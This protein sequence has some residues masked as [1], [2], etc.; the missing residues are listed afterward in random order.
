MKLAGPA[1]ALLVRGR[2]A[3]PQLLLLDG[4]RGGQGRRGA[5]CEG[6]HEPLVLG[7]ERC[8]RVKAV[9]RDEDADAAAMEG[10]WHEHRHAGAVRQIPEAESHPARHLAQRSAWPVRSTSPSAVP[11][12]GKR[13]PTASS[14]VSPAAAATTSSCIL[15]KQDQELAGV[16]ERAAALDHELED[17]VQV[18]F[19]AHRTRDR[20]GCLQPADGALEL[21]AA[22]VDVLVEVGVLDGDRHPARQD[23]EC[24]LVGLVE[25]AALLL[26]QID[27]APGLAAH[28]YRCAEEGR[29]RRM[30]R[31][32]SRSCAGAG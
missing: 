26:G 1:A 31:A 4:L 30:L 14:P 20:D 13:V 28:Q 9:E 11:A 23:E 5:A 19:A 24:L 16:D 2:D 17:T 27:V 21:S 3:H 6:A 32:G 29:H 15:R 8:R 25:L 7:A 22:G 10:E 18:G 12:E